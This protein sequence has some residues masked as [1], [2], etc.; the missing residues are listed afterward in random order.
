MHKWRKGGILLAA[1]TLAYPLAVYLSL[2]RFQPRWLALLL[3]AL[4][5]VRLAVNRTPVTWGM[6]GGAALLAVLSWSYNAWLPL[7][8]YPVA[9]SLLLL[10]LFG[11]SLLHPPTAIERIARLSEPDLPPAA[12][13]YTRRVTQIWCVFFSLNG[14]IALFTAFWASDAI[15]TL[16]NGLISYVLMGT[17]MAGEWLVRRRM[18]ARIAA[19]ASG[20]AGY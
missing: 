6:A 1:L 17:L 16:Y 5:L 10:C 2:E 9:I 8:L 15:W 20:A 11:A 3:L 13:A 12:V 7:K 18:R 19:E 14:L 4:A